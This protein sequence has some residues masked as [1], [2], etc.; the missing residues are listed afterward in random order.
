MG[1]ALYTSKQFID[2]IAGSGGI[3]STIASRIG[4][5]WHTARKYIDNYPT[6]RAAYDDECEKVLDLAE[7]KTIEAIKDGDTS[8]IR[9]YLSTKGKNR[10]YSER[11]EVTGSDGGALTIRYVN[12]WRDNPA[13]A[14]PGT[15]EDT[16]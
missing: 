10:G 11:H 2:A 6:I 13:D 3:V 16:E 15:A 8:M 1:K 14:A 7:A 4:C 5:T 9:Y 12:N